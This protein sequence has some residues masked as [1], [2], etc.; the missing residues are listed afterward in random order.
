MTQLLILY[1]GYGISD[2]CGSCG[3]V[4]LLFCLGF[5]LCFCFVSF[6]VGWEGGL[7]LVLV[8]F[9]ACD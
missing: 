1:F 6:F 5:G 9:N 8:F 7:V 4:F 2:N 3:G